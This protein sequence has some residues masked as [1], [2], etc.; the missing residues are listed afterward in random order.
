MPRKKYKPG[1]HR[2]FLIE[3]CNPVDAGHLKMFPELRRDT[4]LVFSHEKGAKMET[5]VH[6]LISPSRKYKRNDIFVAEYIEPGPAKYPFW[7]YWREVKEENNV[8]G[9][10]S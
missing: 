3:W 9:N 7:R 5:L 1:D 6:L 10:N 2:V 8:T 4:G